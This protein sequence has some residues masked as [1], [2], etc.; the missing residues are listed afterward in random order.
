MMMMNRK[1]FQIPI[2]KQNSE[3]K[4]K[5]LF[6]LIKPFIMRR[7]KSQVAKDLPEKV[8]N[9]HY[10]VMTTMQEEMYEETKN[11]YRTVQFGLNKK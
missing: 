10:S 7:H 5:K 1:Q 9:I 6:S 2:E 11:M 8:E 4:S 3:E